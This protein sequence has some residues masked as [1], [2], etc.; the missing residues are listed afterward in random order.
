MQ[1]YCFMTW[2]EAAGHSRVENNIPSWNGNPEVASG[3]ESQGTHLMFQACLACLAG[4]VGMAYH[5]RR[6]GIVDM[7]EAPEWC[8]GVQSAPKQRSGHP[9]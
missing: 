6:V 9:N 4:Q 5:I 2:G 3:S 8:W 1:D 7:A